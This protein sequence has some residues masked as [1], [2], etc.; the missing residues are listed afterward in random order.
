MGL[1]VLYL[2]IAGSSQRRQENAVKELLCN[3]WCLQLKV[4]LQEQNSEQTSSAE[5][6]RKT[7]AAIAVKFVAID[8]PQPA[9]REH[10]RATLLVLAWLPR[11]FQLSPWVNR[12]VYNIN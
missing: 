12:S 7:T 2:M 4:L 1:S 6:Q 5:V 8:Q 10:V 11:M 9:M 3:Q